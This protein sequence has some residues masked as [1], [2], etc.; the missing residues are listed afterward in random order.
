MNPSKTGIVRII[1]N[2][3]NV[4]IWSGLRTKNPKSPFIWQAWRTQQ[5]ALNN[6]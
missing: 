6:K 4:G 5:D 1:S 2:G 3:L